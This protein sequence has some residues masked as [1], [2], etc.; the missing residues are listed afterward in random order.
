MSPGTSNFYHGA[1]SETRFGSL[2]AIALPVT[3]PLVGT[4]FDCRGPARGTRM[5]PVQKEKSVGL[6]P[7]EFYQHSFACANYWI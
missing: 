4:R 6:W 3:G 1:P 2:G 7:G 5:W